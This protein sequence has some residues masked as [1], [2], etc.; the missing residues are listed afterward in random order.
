M[1]AGLIFILAGVVAM[2]KAKVPPISNIGFILILVG[3]VL[4]AGHV[5]P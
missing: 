3:A 1:S 5:S 2:N 4:V